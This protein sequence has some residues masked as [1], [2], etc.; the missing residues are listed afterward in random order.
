MRTNKIML[1]S[2][3]HNDR[4]GTSCS[5]A[6]VNHGHCALGQPLLPVIRRRASRLR[7]KSSLDDIKNQ[8]SCGHINARVEVEESRNRL[9]VD[10]R[11]QGR[12]VDSKTVWHPLQ[13]LG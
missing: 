10:V 13:P 5:D 6:T 11:V 1:R 3:I 4:C 7:L 9:A 8:G 2:S 12:E